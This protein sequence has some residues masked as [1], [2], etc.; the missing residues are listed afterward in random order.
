MSVFI[1]GDNNQFQRSRETIIRT[2]G[3]GQTSGNGVSQVSYYYMLYHVP[4]EQTVEL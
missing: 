1:V 4:F 3:C 2:A